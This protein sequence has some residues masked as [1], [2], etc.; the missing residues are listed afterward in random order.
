MADARFFVLGCFS[1]RI[2]CLAEAIRMRGGTVFWNEDKRVIGFR[3]R[4][5]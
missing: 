2:G 4:R 1:K 5:G 3:D